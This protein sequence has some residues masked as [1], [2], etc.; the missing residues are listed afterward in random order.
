MEKKLHKIFLEFQE[1]GFTENQAFELTKAILFAY[2]FLVKE[3]SKEE[4]LGTKNETST[5]SQVDPQLLSTVNHP[6]QQTNTSPL[7]P[8]FRSIIADS[9]CYQTCQMN[10]PYLYQ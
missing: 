1:A 10:Q 5:F 3:E 4:P 6:Q 9:C 8:Y 2:P 7:S